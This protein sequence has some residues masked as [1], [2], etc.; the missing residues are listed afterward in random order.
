M[1]PA[2]TQAAQ[3][4][5]WGRSARPVHLGP[6]SLSAHGSRS[7]P[8]CYRE[9]T[10]GDGVRWKARF[11]LPALFA[12]PELIAGEEGLSGVPCAS[13][14]ILALFFS[15]ICSHL[16]T[17]PARGAGA[18]GCLGAS[19]TLTSWSISP[20]HP[21]VLTE[22]SHACHR[23]ASVWCHGPSCDKF[24]LREARSHPQ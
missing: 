21:R 22:S 6:S 7:Q 13:A 3:G 20:E 23:K 5:G 10:F 9:G 18:A 1:N 14:E 17:A 8:T 16:S 4:A 15:P 2:C 24:S 12:L 19:S 11:F